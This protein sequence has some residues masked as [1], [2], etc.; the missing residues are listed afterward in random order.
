MKI[1][2]KQVNILDPA[3]PHHGKIKDVCIENGIIK[4]I[5]DADSIRDQADQIFEGRGKHLSI[6]WFDLHVNFREPGFE[7]KEDLLSGCKAAASG[8][9][10]GVLCMPSTQPAVQS[11]SEIELIR[12]RTKNE[13]TD[14]FASGVL[15]VN[16][17]GKDLSEMYD[18]SQSGALAFTD[19]KR[20]VQDSGLLLRALLYSKN[21][22]SLIM[23][24][25]NDKNIS[26]R[27]QMNEGV[28]STRLG[29]RGMPSLAEEIIINRDLFLAEYAESRIHFSTVS[30]A[31]SIE[32][33]R[34]A[35]KKGIKV[36]CD[37]ASH[38]LFLTDSFLEDFDTSYKVNPPLRT[39]EDMEALKYAV[40]DG[41]IDSICSDHSPEDIENKKKEFDLAAFGI[42][43]LETAFAVANTAMQ[44]TISLEKLVEKFTVN[45][46]S[47]LSLQVPVI[48][49]GEAA[50]L[51]LFDS[52]IEW[53]VEDKHIKS[54]SK[55]TPFIGSTLKGKPVAIFNKGLYCEC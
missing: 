25:A 20:P 47:I 7:Y 44:K 49:E 39:K 22:N 32:L 17:E 4:K 10:T 33:I 37:V 31:K 42:I 35:K 12:N 3:S 45:P 24:F 50:N 52:E 11:K 27:G 34:E 46:R 2:I 28:A 18:M 54:K 16:R 5:S 6:G 40:V 48:K 55:N 21:F 41:T 38:Q 53:K 29:L 51:T 23:S 9:F 36:T 14:V 13:L 15:S 1:L 26:G 30:S 19:D 43:G 8:G